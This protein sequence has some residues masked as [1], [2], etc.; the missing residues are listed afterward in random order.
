M[1]TYILLP[2]EQPVVLTRSDGQTPSF[3]TLLNAL[4][5]G[6]IT[7]SVFSCLHYVLCTLCPAPCTLRLELLSVVVVAMLR[8]VVSCRAV[9]CRALQCRAV[10]CRAVSCCV[11]S[12]HAVLLCRAVSCRVV[13]CCAVSCRVV[14]CCAVLCCAVPCRA[15]PCRAVLLCCS[16]VCLFCFSLFL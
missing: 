6:K 11:V 14:S 15:V 13:L 16:F 3:P 9:Q 12:C 7:V 5:V 10:L 4:L 8:R 2:R 1:V